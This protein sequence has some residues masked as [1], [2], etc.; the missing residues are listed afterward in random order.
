AAMITGSL[1]DANGQPVSRGASVSLRPVM[2]DLMQTNFMTTGTG[3][4]PDGTFRF[5]V[6]PGEYE[7]EARVMQPGVNGPPPP[8]SE[9]FGRA[10]VSVAGDT[11]VTIALGGGARITG[12]VAFDG[13]SA[14]PGL[15]AKDN[16]LFVM[17]TP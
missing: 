14:L 8:G 10:R 12:R 9:Q 7:L 17:M 2:K 4:R 3:V 1:V 13:T 5:R 11:S 16:G 6:A 15:G